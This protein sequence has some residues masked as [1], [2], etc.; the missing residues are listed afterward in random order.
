M[1]KIAILMMLTLLA[2]GCG[3]SNNSSQAAAGGSWQA[4]L[5]GGVGPAS[6]FSFITAFTV[7]GDGSLSISNFQFLTTGT[8]FVSGETES[9]TLIV[10]TN[11]QNTVTGTLKFVVTSGSPSGNTLTLNGSEV[12]NTITGNWTLTGSNGCAST[13]PFT[14]TQS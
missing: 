3:S 10:T 5:S 4:Q 8:C 12:A 6:G 9:G 11:S 14:M 2:N 1:K 7:N 13:G